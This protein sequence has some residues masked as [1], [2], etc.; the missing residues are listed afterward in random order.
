MGKMRIKKVEEMIK[1]EVEE[2]MKKDVEEMTKKEV[3]EMMKK[4]LME[5]I[6]DIFKYVEFKD[7]DERLAIF[8]K[9]R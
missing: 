1:K 2:M 7:F 9:R 5:N 3:E 8:N 4:K 6:V